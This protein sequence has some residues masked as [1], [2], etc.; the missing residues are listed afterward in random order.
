LWHHLNFRR[1]GV[2][3][4]RYKVHVWFGR[5]L[6]LMGIIDGGL[7]LRLAAN[8]NRGELITYIVLSVV[9]FLS[10]VILSV[11]DL[12]EKERTVKAEDSL[13]ESPVTK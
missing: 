10:Y 8:Y 11:L 2:R 1:R 7:G 9:F 5:A 13:P 4:W 12:W 3:S 6:I